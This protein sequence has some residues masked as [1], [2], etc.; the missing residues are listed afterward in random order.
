MNGIQIPFVRTG[1]TTT[2][3]HKQSFS[4]VD[5]SSFLDVH[6]QYLLSITTISA[7]ERSGHWS[8]QPFI[9]ERDH[10]NENLERWR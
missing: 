8:S 4:R 1:K 9:S 3:P 5:V 7:N 2:R 10:E 6:Q